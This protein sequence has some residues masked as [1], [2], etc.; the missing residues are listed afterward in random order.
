MENT[1]ARVD[2]ASRCAAENASVMAGG[3]RMPDGADMVV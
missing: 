2:S 1:T 3:T